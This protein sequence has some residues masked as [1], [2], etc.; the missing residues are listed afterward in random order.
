MEVDKTFVPIDIFLGADGVAAQADGLA[1]A[2]GEQGRTARHPDPYCTEGTFYTREYGNLRPVPFRAKLLESV[3]ARGIEFPREEAMSRESKGFKGRSKEDVEGVGERLGREAGPSVPSYPPE[4]AELFQRAEALEKRLTALRSQATLSDLRARLGTL[5]AALRDLPAA[6]LEVRQGGYIYKAYL[7]KKV[8]VLQKQ[9]EGLRQRLDTEAAQQSRMFLEQVDRLQ[10]RLAAL[11]SEFRP[12]D[13]QVLEKEVSFLE[14]QV[15]DV[16]EAL[17]G[18]FQTLQGNVQQT[19]RQIEALRWLLQQIAGASFRLRP[20]E[21]VVE[22]V[23]AQY[24]T[25]QEKEGPRGILFLTDQRLIFEQKED[26]VTTKF[27]FIPTEKQRVQ[28]VLLGAPIGAVAEMQAGERGA[29]MFKKELLRLAFSQG[30]VRQAL[31]RL[32]ADSE[33]WAAWIGRVRS[34]DIAGERVGAAAAPIVQASPA[35]MPECCPTCGAA[36]QVEVVRGMAS[37]T[38]EYCGTVIRL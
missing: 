18:T 24:L 14:G 25:R 3:P 12:A 38:C 6:L 19:Q 35:Q 7:E 8:D 13:L 31:F 26:V 34:G 9:W 1:E 15:G 33:A 21:N 27:L 10:R 4:Q 37:I 22:A 17:E 5:D 30:D 16:A 28:K 36:L 11:G 32:E 23:S 20:E 2:V 29:L